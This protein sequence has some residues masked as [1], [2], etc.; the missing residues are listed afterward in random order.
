MKDSKEQTNMNEEKLIK[1]GEMNDWDLVDELLRLTF[2]SGERTALAT[3]P[4]M[5]LKH[6]VAE[7]R[8]ELEKRLAHS[9]GNEPRPRVQIP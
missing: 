3:E 7:L 8:Y 6:N 1:A 4:D 9:I 5:E 2:I